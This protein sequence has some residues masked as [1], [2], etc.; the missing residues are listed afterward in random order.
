[1]LGVGWKNVEESSSP[2][3]PSDVWGSP[4]DELRVKCSWRGEDAMPNIAF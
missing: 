4:S 1:M 2:D 3:S